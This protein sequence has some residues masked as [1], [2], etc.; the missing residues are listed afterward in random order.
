MPRITVITRNGDRHE[1]EAAVDLTAMEVIREAGF[2][3]LLA[4]CGGCC[5][6]ATCH[7][8]VDEGGESLSPMGVDED[9]LLDGSSHRTRTSRLSCQLHLG[10]GAD[11]LCIRLAPED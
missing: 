8:Y 4:M 10:D 6:C 2:D 9:D 1:V 3:E 5:S 11:G 7:V